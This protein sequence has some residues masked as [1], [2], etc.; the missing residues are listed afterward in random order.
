MP[1]LFCLEPFTRARPKK[2]ARRLPIGSDRAEMVPGERGPRQERMEVTIKSRE[3]NEKTK[4][5][6]EACWKR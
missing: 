4:S 5:R 2:P 1:V 6:I 3:S